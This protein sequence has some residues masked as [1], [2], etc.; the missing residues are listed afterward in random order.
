MEPLSNVDMYVQCW[1][2][3]NSD[4]IS[5]SEALDDFAKAEIPASKRLQIYEALVE[6]INMDVSNITG[7]MNRDKEQLRRTMFGELKS[8]ILPLEG[9]EQAEEIFVTLK[10]SGTQ[11]RP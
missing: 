8:D 5:F 10:M 4:Y 7:F 3:Y 2:S 11:Y 9:I 1:R 6:Q